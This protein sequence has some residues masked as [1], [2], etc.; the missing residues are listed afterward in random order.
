MEILQG[1][2]NHTRDQ[3]HHIEMINTFDKLLV[4][5]TELRKE[6]LTLKISQ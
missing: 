2:K 1:T 4:D 6:S 5:G 3:K